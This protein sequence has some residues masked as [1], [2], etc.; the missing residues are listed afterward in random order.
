MATTPR[1]SG[2][3]EPRISIQ[4]RIR[5]PAVRVRSRGRPSMTA[6]PN[7]FNCPWPRRRRSPIALKKERYHHRGAARRPTS[8][9]RFTLSGL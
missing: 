4:L 8:G 2:A 9:L 1:L 5:R 6:D 3:L 7:S